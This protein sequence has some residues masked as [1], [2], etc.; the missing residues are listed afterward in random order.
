MYALDLPPRMQGAGLSSPMQCTFSN[1]TQQ[2]SV[3]AAVLNGTTATCQAPAWT[4]GR[5][6]TP[7]QLSLANGQ[8]IS[9]QLFVYYEEPQIRAVQPQLA[10]RYGSFQM[11]VH[12]EDDLQNLTREHVRPLVTA[13][14]GRTAAAVPCG[15]QAA[16]I[17]HMLRQL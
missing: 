7:V 4:A 12:V 9:K 3:Q 5:D 15:E 16:V 1:V 2:L 13:A 11:M 14:A 10:P 17:A 8:C 6:A